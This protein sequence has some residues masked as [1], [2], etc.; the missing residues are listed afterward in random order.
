MDCAS[1]T[2]SVSQVATTRSLPRYKERKIGREEK[3]R[4]R[5]RTLDNKYTRRGIHKQEYVGF[6]EFDIENVS[7]EMDTENSNIEADIGLDNVVIKP[8]DSIDANKVTRKK[9]NLEQ[10]LQR[11]KALL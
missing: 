2:S 6:D 4:I 1:D 8:T 5:S 10:F 7:L 11:L 3:I 9:S